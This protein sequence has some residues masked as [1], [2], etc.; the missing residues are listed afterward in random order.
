MPKVPV[1]DSS[2]NPRTLG[3]VA[4]FPDQPAAPKKPM[5]LRA[6]QTVALA[7]MLAATRQL[8]SAERAAMQRRLLADPRA[9]T[10]GEWLDD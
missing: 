10:A 6:K 5:E 4:P 1:V 2:R 9:W 7:E 8:P 3:D